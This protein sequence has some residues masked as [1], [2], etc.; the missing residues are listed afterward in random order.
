MYKVHK[1]TNSNL[2]EF[3]YGENILYDKNVITKKFN[4]YFPN[5]G[6]NLSNKIKTL[7]NKSFHQYL[8]QK[9]IDKFNF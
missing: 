6:P 5:I 1:M 7:R 9:Y 2:I 3:T 4:E 8:S